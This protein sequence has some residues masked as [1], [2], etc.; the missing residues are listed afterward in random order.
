MTWPSKEETHVDVPAILFH[1]FPKLS[2]GLDI[3][4]IDTGP[5]WKDGS[6]ATCC[7]SLDDVLIN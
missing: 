2:T 3:I 5:S 1:V 7:G 4:V 6:L